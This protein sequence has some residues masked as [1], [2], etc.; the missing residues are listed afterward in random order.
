[1]EGI[2]PMVEMRSL[3]NA[4]EDAVSRR[5]RSLVPVWQNISDMDNAHAAAAIESDGIDILIDLSGHTVG[6]RLGV[7]ALRPAPVQVTYMGYLGSTGLPQI[8]YRISDAMLDP[9]GMTEGVQTE[10]LVRTKASC[11]SFA[12]ERSAPAPTALPALK[13]GTLT[14]G[15][16][17]A[18][19][20]LNDAVLA[21]WRRLLIEVAG[22]KLILVLEHGEQASVCDT[23]LD[24]FS[25]VGVDPQRIS[26]R[27]RQ[28]LS[29]FFSCI[30][31]C[32]LLLDP[33]PYNGGT[34]TFH[35]LWM[36]VPVITLAGE[37]ALGRCGVMI[38]QSVG[39]PEF[40]AQS[41]DEYVNIARRCADDLPALARIRAG[42][43]NK[44]IAAPFADPARVALE[45]ENI[46][47]GLWR[48][49]CDTA[50]PN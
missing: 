21:L 23:M 32:D 12:P 16:L 8:R 15:S 6:N 43:R 24:F 3:A 22:S 45:L 17:N 5:L 25:S 41:A 38:M 29:G 31:E 19:R 20:K 49:W 46:Y 30:Q 50:A 13:N 1:M 2:F 48:N 37:N 47:R 40:I 10:T 7:F 34:T 14:F 18:R 26:I 28:S 42:L 36:G 4:S 35:S 11:V 44:F 27:G 9:P 33:F 39:L